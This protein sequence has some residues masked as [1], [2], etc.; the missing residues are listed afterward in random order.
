MDAELLCRLD[1]VAFT[2]LEDRV[3]IVHFHIV[4]STEVRQIARRG[5]SVRGYDKLFWQM[6]EL[7]RR[8][9]TEDKRMFDD[10]LQFAYVSRKT[11]GE[12]SFQRGLGDSVDRLTVT[13]IEQADKV[14]AEQRD[15]GEPFPK[16][17]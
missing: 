1:S 7:N 9:S 16:W 8:F 10:V 14:I 3:K 17:R 11:M 6:G 15:I 5:G 13:A 4:E 2:L 12:Q